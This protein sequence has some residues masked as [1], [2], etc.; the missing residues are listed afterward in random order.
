MSKSNSDVKREGFINK[1]ANL[2]PKDEYQLK[3]GAQL[4]ADQ[5]P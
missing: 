1:V 4:L 2:G 5:N 3:L